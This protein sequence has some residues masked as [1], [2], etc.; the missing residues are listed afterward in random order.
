MDISRIYHVFGHTKDT[1]TFTEAKI[2]EVGYGT[3]GGIGCVLWKWRLRM[4]QLKSEIVWW[5]DVPMLTGVA[6]GCS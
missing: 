4:G 1:S 3:W 5:W 6:R 2:H